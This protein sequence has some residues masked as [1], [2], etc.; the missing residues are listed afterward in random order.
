[1]WSARTLIKYWAI[2][3]AGWVIVLPVAWLLAA[4][5]GW[6]RWAAWMIFG[7]WVAKDVALYPLSWRSYDSRGW[8]ALAYPVEGAEGIAMRRL[9]PAGIVRIGGE[10]WNAELAARG[11]SVEDGEAV[12]V[13][14]RDGMTLVVESLDRGAA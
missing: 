2:Q 14:G 9:N 6:P 11:R 5:F 10:L 1:M 3:L 4:G 8:T 12:R 13:T 7:L